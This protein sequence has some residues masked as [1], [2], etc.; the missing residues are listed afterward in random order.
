MTNLKDNNFL[1]CSHIDSYS[2]TYEGAVFSL[3][4]LFTSNIAYLSPK[5]TG[6]HEQ[7]VLVIL[8]F[9]IQSLYDSLTYIPYCMG[10]SKKLLTSRRNVLQYNGEVYEIHKLSKMPRY[11]SYIIRVCRFVVKVEFSFPSYTARYHSSSTKP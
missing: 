6:I 4:C 5:C 11:N 2:L 1:I 10:Y 9:L 7:A 3:L 8:K